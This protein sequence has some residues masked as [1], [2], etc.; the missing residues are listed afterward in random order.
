MS[1]TPASPDPT[2]EIVNGDEPLSDRAIEALADL[3]IAAAGDTKND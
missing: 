1:T 3:L 2:I